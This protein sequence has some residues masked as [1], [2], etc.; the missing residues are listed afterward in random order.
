MLQVSSNSHSGNATPCHDRNMWRGY[1]VSRLKSALERVC[2]KSTM[3]P[4]LIQRGSEGAFCFRYHS[5]IS[6]EFMAD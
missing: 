3:F 6:I 5:S 4:T 2:F 1:Q